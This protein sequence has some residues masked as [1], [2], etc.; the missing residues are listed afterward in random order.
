MKLCK[1]TLDNGLSA[2]VVAGALKPRSH[3][4]SSTLYRSLMS[5]NEGLTAEG[6]YFR[7]ACNFY[8][9]ASFMAVSSKSHIIVPAFDEESKARKEFSGGCRVTTLRQCSCVV[10]FPPDSF[11]FFR[12][13]RSY[14]RLNPFLCR[15]LCSISLLISRHKLRPLFDVVIPLRFLLL[16]CLVPLNTPFF[17]ITEVDKSFRK[18][19]TQI[20]R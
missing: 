11:F 17:T 8:C 14:S 7:V 13:L 2:A 10:H 16:P 19:Q 15:F 1:E 5:R 6:Q 12:I 9:V 3:V 4:P 18:L 20:G